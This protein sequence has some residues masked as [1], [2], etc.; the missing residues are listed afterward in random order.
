MKAKVPPTS[1]HPQTE[2][3]EPVKSSGILPPRENVYELTGVCDRRLTLCVDRV[4]VLPLLEA[5]RF[6]LFGL[7]GAGDD[8]GL[9]AS[10]VAPF[11]EGRSTA[12]VDFSFLSDGLPLRPR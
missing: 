12:D 7:S 1:V 10:F 2:S 8:S 4:P 3:Q 11:E 9:F 6:R 5:V